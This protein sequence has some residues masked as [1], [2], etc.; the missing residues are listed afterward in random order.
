MFLML[1]FCLIYHI[2]LQ[3][4]FIYSSHFKLF[5]FIYITLLQTYFYLVFY[6]PP[7]SLKAHKLSSTDMQKRQ[8]TNYFPTALI[9]KTVQS[10]FLIQYVCFLS[11]SL[12]QIKAFS[13]LFAS[14][15]IL[16]IGFFSLLTNTSSIS[17]L[18]CIVCVCVCVCVYSPNGF[19]FY[20]F[21]C[22]LPLFIFYFFSISFTIHKL[23]YFLLSF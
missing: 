14:I 16:Y 15:F 18:N 13:P 12:S 1:I 17:L 8:Q 22:V 5:L 19:A 6:P 7:L 3:Y 4:F 11:F 9:S 10:S 2:F 20:H 21:F 23:Q